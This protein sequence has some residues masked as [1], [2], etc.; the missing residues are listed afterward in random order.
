MG[1][2]LGQAPT[3]G[4]EEKQVSGGEFDTLGEAL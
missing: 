2:V 3:E 1:I 4:D